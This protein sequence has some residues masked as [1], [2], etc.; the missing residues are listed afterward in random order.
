[1][2]QH[3]CIIEVRWADLDSLGHVNNAVYFTYFESARISLIQQHGGLSQKDNVAVV[4][5]QCNIT[6]INPTPFPSS[7][8]VI[9]T[10]PKFGNTS[11]TCH[12][13]LKNINEDI[14]YSEGD[15]TLVWLNTIDKQPIQVPKALKQWAIQTSD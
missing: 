8:K 1:M 5:V 3:E 2:N 12:H 6:Y 9:T 14:I 4:V 15:I 10:I 13:S 11:M 7:L